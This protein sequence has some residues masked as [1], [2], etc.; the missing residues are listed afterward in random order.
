MK[1]T[2]FERII[3][4][5]SSKMKEVLSDP[6]RIALIDNPSERLQMAAVRQSSSALMFIDNPTTQVQSMA[7]LGN[8]I[9]IKFIK[10]PSEM[11]Q[12]MIISLDARNI[13]FIENPSPQ[14]QLSAVKK[15]PET[16]KLIENPSVETIFYY[17]NGDFSKL[18]DIQNIPLSIQKRAISVNPLNAQYIHNLDKDLQ[19]ETL[20]LTS[21]ILNKNDKAE[22][23]QSSNAQSFYKSYISFEESYASELHDIKNM[24]IPEIDKSKKIETIKEAIK[25]SKILAV[26]TLSNGLGH[27]INVKNIFKKI[28]ESNIEPE[29]LKAGEWMQLLS[30]GKCKIENKVL[31]INLLDDNIISVTETQTL[32]P[33][34]KDNKV[35]SENFL[36]K[37]TSETSKKNFDVKSINSP[38]SS[39]LLA[40]E[41]KE[42]FGDIKRKVDYKSLINSVEK[43]G[44]NPSEL[45]IE[46]WRELIKKGN[47]SLKDYSL[48]LKKTPSGYNITKT[49][50]SKV[51]A[52]IQAASSVKRTTEKLNAEA[53]IQN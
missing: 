8:P 10:K 4:L 24:N 30:T 29:N 2:L 50:L 17:I 46:N 15:N 41:I 6:C 35:V 1:P 42:K 32:Y 12:N 31:E 28:S 52:P 40:T 7:V 16:I 38:S 25:D 3:S 18:A 51:S 11:V 36:D 9:Y 27:N 21:R 53:E 34:K 22:Q 45:N 5:F 20:E 13:S 48:N 26:Q 33:P 19:K 23:V 49:A 43:T 14:L 44:I 39:E 37:D 47:T